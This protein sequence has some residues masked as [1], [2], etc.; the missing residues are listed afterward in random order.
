MA[1]RPFRSESRL[2]DVVLIEAGATMRMSPPRRLPVSIVYVPVSANVGGT[3]TFCPD[4]YGS[5]RRFPRGF[6]FDTD[7][8]GRGRP[9]AVAFSRQ[10]CEAE[11]RPPKAK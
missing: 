4:L 1:G 2:V 10:A 11:A 6:G 7:A 3:V 9:E 5:T 8:P